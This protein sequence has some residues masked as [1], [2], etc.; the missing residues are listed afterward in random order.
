MISKETLLNILSYLSFDEYRAICIKLY[1][2]HDKLLNYTIDIVDYQGPILS[3]L[4]GTTMTLGFGFKNFALDERT[5]IKNLY[6]TKDIIKIGSNF[7]EHIS[8]YYDIPIIKKSNRGRKAGKKRKKRGG[9]YFGSSTTF[10]IPDIPGKEKY[11]D[12]RTFDKIYKVKVYRT[13]NG[14]IPGVIKADYSDAYRI[15]D[16]LKNYLSNYAGRALEYD[17]SRA[18]PHMR[19][20]I[21]NLMYVDELKLNIN[22]IAI[23]PRLQIIKNYYS[24]KCV[25]EKSPKYPCDHITSAVSLY[26]SSNSISKF[27]TNTTEP[28]LKIFNVSYQTAKNSSIVTVK[29]ELP[30]PTEK[31]KYLTVK[32]YK[33]KIMFVGG[34]FLPIINKLHQWLTKLIINNYNTIIDDE[35][36]EEPESESS[37]TCDDDYMYDT[38]YNKS[39]N[40]FFTD[41]IIEDSYIGL[42]QLDTTSIIKNTDYYIE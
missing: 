8:K 30:V 9:K 16:I 20:V 3:K 37:D 13:G 27:L 28:P 32:I 2:Y 10:Y 34:L 26:M 29:F 1:Q 17:E 23:G 24:D 36:F 38:N 40:D 4:T 15:L 39:S 18:V 35:V 5:E 41:N 21:A 42:R 19:N 25:C 31:D 12:H 11:Y 6:T 22:S 7:G 33:Q 14:Q